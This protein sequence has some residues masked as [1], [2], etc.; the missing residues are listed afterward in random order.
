MRYIFFIY[1]SKDTYFLFY[2]LFEAAHTLNDR[3]RIVICLAYWP[4]WTTIYMRTQQNCAII[5]I[6]SVL[7]TTTL[8]I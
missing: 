5:Y 3:T 6:L 2:Y 7:W 4:L 1:F 8:V